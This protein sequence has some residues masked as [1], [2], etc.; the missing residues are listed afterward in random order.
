MQIEDVTGDPTAIA[1]S[2]DN[3]EL[4][5]VLEGQGFESLALLRCYAGPQ[6]SFVSSVLVHRDGTAFGEAEKHKSMVETSARTILEDGAIVETRVKTSHWKKAV[7]G[8]L[9]VNHASA[10]FYFQE[11]EHAS[12][13]WAVHGERI[14]RVAADRKTSIPR[15]DSVDLFRVA[16]DRALRVG[17]IQW[18]GL[19]LFVIPVMIVAILLAERF[20]AETGELM[21]AGFVL[22]LLAGRLFG[23]TVMSWLPFPRVRPLAELR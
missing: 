8:P 7:F 20:E 10:G 21:M 13:L 23:R 22:G 18:N 19:A 5:P 15:H 3:P 9:R 11:V 4:I 1:E 6:T 16:S 14:Q 12:G 17:I 2:I